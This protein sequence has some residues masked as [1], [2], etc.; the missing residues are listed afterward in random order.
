MS[1]DS[2][3]P[4]HPSDDGNARRID[5]KKVGGVALKIGRV[6]MPTVMAILFGSP[7]DGWSDLL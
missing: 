1:N 4:E 2:K 3:T 5:W 7:L 6:A